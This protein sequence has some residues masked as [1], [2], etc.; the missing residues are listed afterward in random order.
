MICWIRIS[1]GVAN[2]LAEHVNFK[3]SDVLYTKEIPQSKND[4]DYDDD[5]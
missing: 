4:E 5:R 3:V 2:K 1:S